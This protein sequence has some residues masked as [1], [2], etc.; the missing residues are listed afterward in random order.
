MGNY[1][2]CMLA[3][4][5]ERQS[6]GAKVILLSGEI[7]Q[8]DGHVK[9]AELIFEI[10]NYFLGNFRSLQIGR[11]FST[12][13]PDE[14][15]E[16]GNVYIMFP[17]KRVNFVIKAADMGA[18][19]ISANRAANWASSTGAVHIVSSTGVVRIE[20]KQRG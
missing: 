19:F 18:L 2:S 11:R 12:L 5:A 7:Q 1:I 15:L 4:P 10:S 3:N 20:N 13:S 6:R 17:M 9:A 8:L 16:M 14:D